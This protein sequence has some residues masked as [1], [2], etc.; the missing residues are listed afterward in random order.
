[1]L[2]EIEV[3][4]DARRNLAVVGGTGISAHIYADMSFM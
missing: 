1:M 3:V 2:D 4:A